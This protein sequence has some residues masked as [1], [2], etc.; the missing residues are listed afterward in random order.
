MGDNKVVHSWVY[1]RKGVLAMEYVILAVR[2]TKTEV[3]GRPFCLTS[4]GQGIRSF[5]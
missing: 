2:D 4:I 5:E 3:F 1:P